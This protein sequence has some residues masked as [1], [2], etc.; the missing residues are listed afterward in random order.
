MTDAPPGEQETSARRGR[1]G[2]RARATIRRL[3]ARV[4][5]DRGHLSVAQQETGGGTWPLEGCF[6]CGG[7]LV[8]QECLGQSFQ[9]R[10]ATYELTI[11]L[12]EL[13]STN[14]LAPLRRPPWRFNPGGQAPA[15]V[16]DA[17]WGELGNLRSRE[18]AQAAWS[19]YPAFVRQC[20]VA[21]TVEAENEEQ[22]RTAAVAL[23]DQLDVWW[24]SFTDWLGVLVAQDFAGLGTR[25]Y[26]LLEY[27]FN[28]WS[29]DENGV[30]RAGTGKAVDRVQR[31]PEV[32]GPD[33]LQRAMDL[34][35]SCQRP[36][37]EWLFIRDAR[38]LLGSGAFRRAVIDAATAAE[39]TL[40]AL[41]D[42][43][44]AATS[45][46]PAISE[47]LLERSQTLGGRCKLV[48]ELMRGTL[49]ARFQQEVTEPRN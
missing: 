1:R 5:G 49:P 46:D 39:L 47:A 33:Q 30:R 28:A 15:A 22:F 34:A 31:Y 7:L 12:P 41:L 25:R 18:S 40:T 38:S 48:N 45:T 19:E 24:S 13:D 29:G 20:I 6:T 27:G 4:F 9:T 35:A 26:S 23:A 36:P 16:V 43:H 32:L 3:S 10:T 2:G 17:E 21:S 14:A 11:T 44:F 37:T 42:R 8:G